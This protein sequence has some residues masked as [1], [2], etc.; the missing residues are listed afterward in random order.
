MSFLFGWVGTIYCPYF[1]TKSGRKNI[2]IIITAGSASELKS[3]KTLLVH[4][5][6]GIK[7]NLLIPIKWS[8]Y[9]LSDSKSCHS[10]YLYLIYLSVSI[11]HGV[12]L[13]LPT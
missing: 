13:L 4:P 10:K 7:F 9:N 6:C 12:S 11:V 1:Q 2:G 5:K 8:L 3:Q